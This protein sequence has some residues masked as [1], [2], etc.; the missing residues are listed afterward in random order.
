MNAS[1][2]VVSP[3]GEWLLFVSNL[4]GQ[5]QV[6]IRRLQGESPNYL[7]SR[8]SG[9]QPRWRRDMKEVFY[10]DGNRLVAVPVSIAAEPTIGE[11]SVL[12]E[13][14][15]LRPRNF[16]GDL[17]FDTLDGQRFYVNEQRGYVENPITVTL[18][19]TALLP[20]TNHSQ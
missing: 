7:V 18:N 12:F 1:T 17:Q 10:V 2:F 9:N 6:Y 5:D 15:A 14:P 8:S 3:D 20:R 19:W 11:P 4:S 16:V 13:V